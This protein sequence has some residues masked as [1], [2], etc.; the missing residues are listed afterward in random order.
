MIHELGASA[1]Q[2]LPETIARYDRA[3]IYAAFAAGANGFLL[4][5]VIDAAPDAWRRAPYRTVPHETQFG[6]LTHDRTPRPARRRVPRDRRYAGADRPGGGR[7]RAGH[8]GNDRSLGVVQAGRR[9]QPHG[10]GRP[11]PGS[12]SPITRTTDSSRGF[13]VVPLPTRTCI[14]CAPSS[15]RSSSSARQ[16]RSRLLCAN[17]RT[18]RSPACSCS[19]PLSPARNATSLTS[20]R[21][22]GEGCGAT[23]LPAEP[24][25][26]R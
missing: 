23:S 1:A 17:T 26:R 2:Y 15:R 9:L 4:W 10:H 24:S 7:A 14:S 3:S 12:M 5:D 20:T 18:G 6:L 11:A 8:R 19:P 21:P 16:G 25:T 13:R 22:S